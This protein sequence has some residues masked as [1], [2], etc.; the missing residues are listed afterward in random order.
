MPSSSFAPVSFTG[1]IDGTNTVFVCPVNYS[2]V[3]VEL[4]G[5]TLT[6]GKDYTRSGLSFVFTLPPQVGDILRGWVFRR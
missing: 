2:S 3:M 4:N 5:N 6:D 1:T